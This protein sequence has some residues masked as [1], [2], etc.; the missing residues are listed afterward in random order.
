MKYLF[1]IILTIL[2]INTLTV[3]SQDS[4]WSRIEFE[5]QKISAAIPQTNLVDAEKRSGGQRLHIVAFENGVEME[6]FHWKSNYAPGALNT[7]N[8]SGDADKTKNQILKF[9]DYHILKTSS[10][11]EGKIVSSKLAIVWD[12]NLFS[13]SVRSKTGDEKEVA[14]FFLSIKIEGQALIVK[15]EKT[16]FPEKTISVSDLRSSPE[17]IEAEKRQTGKFEGKI[18]YELKSDEKIVETETLTHRALFIDKPHP[19]FD[20][21]TGFTRK[22]EPVYIDLLVQLRADGQIGDIVVTSSSN[23]NFTQNSINAARRI[24]FVPARRDGKF[25]DSFQIVKYAMVAMPTINTIIR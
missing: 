4:E 3:F 25:V 18:T 22:L 23:E 1:S 7:I 15:D 17:V 14:R 8:N 20:S 24:K 6:I 21:T 2:F 10:V 12:G 9:G 11:K 16:N 19:R 13:F 5:D